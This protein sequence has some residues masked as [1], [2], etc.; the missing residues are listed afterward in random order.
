[1][2]LLIQNAA[3]S[4][5]KI[6]DQLKPEYDSFIFLKYVTNASKINTFMKQINIIYRS[7]LVGLKWATL[8]IHNIPIFFLFGSNS[9]IGHCLNRESDS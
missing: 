2:D 7:A 5:R 1:M 4:H 8:S 9:Y 3:C 6:Q